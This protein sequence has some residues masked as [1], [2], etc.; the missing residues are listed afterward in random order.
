MIA[1]EP[2]GGGA[3]PSSLSQGAM[4]KLFSRTVS[5]PRSVLDHQLVA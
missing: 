3:Q 1:R 2:G 4:T 5:N